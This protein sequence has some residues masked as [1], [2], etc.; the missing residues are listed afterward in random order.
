MVAVDLDNK[1]LVVVAGSSF[2]SADTD[3]QV[4]IEELASWF[5]WPDV[6]PDGDSIMR[7]WFAA[8]NQAVLKELIGS[9]TE[10]I[11]EAGS[12]HGLSAQFLLTT[13][14]DAVVICN[15][16]WLGSLEHHINP[17]WRA[18]LANLY[19]TFLNNLWDQRGRVIPMRATIQDGMRIIEHLEIYPDLIYIDGSHDTNSVYEDVSTSLRL[20]PDSAVVGDDANWDSV[21]QGVRQATAVWPGLRVETRGACWW[22]R[23]D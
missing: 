14:S 22:I 17:V 9:D 18:D 2:H 21:I 13:A 7:G 16:H 6:R 1:A 11:Y 20:F 12:Y 3:G 10:V 5:P 4:S 23:S 8:E 19:Q 15:D